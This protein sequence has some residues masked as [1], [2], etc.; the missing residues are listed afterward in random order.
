LRAVSLYSGAGGLDLGFV[1]EGFD[2]TWAIDNDPFA[3]D[4]YN[5]NLE[6]VAVC[7]DVL[8]TGPPPE[9]RPDVV[10]GGPPCQGFSV[11]GRMDPYDPRNQH[12]ENFLDVV[13]ALRPRAF[14]MENIKA[15]GTSPRWASVREWLLQRSQDLGFSTEIFILNASHY[16]VPQARERMFMIGIR[17]G[18]PQYP[19][20]SR[21]GHSTTVRSTLSNL[22]VFCSPGNDDISKVRVVP[23]CIP[24]V[25][26]SA[27]K[28]SLL[29]NGSGRPLDL[30][31]P[32]KTLTASGGNSLPIIDQLELEEGADPWVVEYYRYL[33]NKGLPIDEAPD[34]M[35]RITVQEFAALQTFPQDW[36]WNGPQ[37]AR[38][39]QI[40]N[41]VPPLLA[42]AVAR[43]IREVLDGRG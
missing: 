31:S 21:N 19:I 39:R 3:V 10:V 43:S 27:Y 14:V 2:I 34:R 28:G 17:D 35:R 5:A 24:V 8:K 20:P 25:R 15:L 12:V 22:P 33:K 16:G 29:F 41:A 23:A 38:Y 9:F 7:G 4:T 18:T 32:A 13:E 11:I 1:R 6:Q 30:D 42:E 37:S 36:S 26:G 40:G